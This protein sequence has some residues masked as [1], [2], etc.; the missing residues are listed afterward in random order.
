MNLVPGLGNV[1]LS[2]ELFL[3]LNILPYGCQDPFFDPRSVM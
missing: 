1:Q 2:I 3:I